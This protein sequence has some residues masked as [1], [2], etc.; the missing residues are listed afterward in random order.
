MTRH[1]RSDKVPLDKINSLVAAGRLDCKLTSN[2]V[3]LM[4]VVVNAL[5]APAW[6][7][8]G[9][10]SSYTPCPC[11]AVAS[12]PASQMSKMQDAGLLVMTKE[13]GIVDLES[14]AT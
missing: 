5:L 6:V 4:V 14:I 1:L 10:S 13:A 11:R 7:P 12:L 3:L 9:R 2:A 8:R